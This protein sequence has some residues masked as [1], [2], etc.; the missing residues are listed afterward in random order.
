MSDPNMFRFVPVLAILFLIITVAPRAFVISAR[1]ASSTHNEISTATE[2]R[3]MEP[4]WWPTKGTPARDQ[5]VG[6]QSCGRCHQDIVETQ[7]N[8][9]MAHA[10]TPATTDAFT[11]IPQTMNFRAGS[12]NY[13]L[14][15]TETGAEYSVTNLRTRVYAEDKPAQSTFKNLKVLK[16]V[17]PDQMIPAMQFISASLGVQCEFCH[18]HDAFDRDDKHSK[19]TAR[20]M[21]QMT[22]AVNA[23]QFHCERAVTCYTCHR[24]YSKPVTIPMVDSTAPYVSEARSAPDPT[25]EG[26]TDL[27][28]ADVVLEKY[29]Q[30]LG[31][32]AA[33]QNVSSRVETGTVSFGVG[34]AFPIEI[35]S[36]SPFRQAIIMHLPAGDGSTVFDSQKGWFK[37]AGGPVRDMPQAD[38]EGAKLDADLQFPIDVKKTYQ[39]LK[40]I[41]TERINDR[42]AI[43][44]FATNSSGPPLELY[45]D[46]QSGLLLRQLRFGPS[47]LGLNPIQID[48][49]DY[50]TFDGV[51]VPLHLLVAR[52]NR[53]VD[54]HLLQVTQNVPIDDAKLARP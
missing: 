27:P 33:I 36:E 41:R 34:P 22:L 17:P 38:I 6:S 21:I 39:E 28:S 1:S 45:F 12:F 19:Q 50:R 40:V 18:V 43:L 5:Y 31:G 32:A 35:L 23:D 47:P 14:S 10:E 51:Q 42:D 8:T 25:N 11:N 44:L 4:G 46:R 3:L 29:V 52:P 54:I 20:R 24:G 13:S 9:P 48:Y 49:G 30:A 2:L 37:P 15:Q 26:R 53:T 7:K 16:D